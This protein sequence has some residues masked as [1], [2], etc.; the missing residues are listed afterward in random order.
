MHR[1]RKH[2]ESPREDQLE[3]VRSCVDEIEK[4][5]GEIKELLVEDFGGDVLIKAGSPKTNLSGVGDE[6]LEATHPYRVAFVYKEHD[7]GWYSSREQLWTLGKRKRFRTVDGLVY[8]TLFAK[9]QEAAYK[10]EEACWAQLASKVDAGEVCSP[11]VC[12]RKF[13]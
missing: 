2:G 4:G 7:H 5:K 8:L 10:A 11:H 6:V 13:D 9:D 3:E 12:A 1:L